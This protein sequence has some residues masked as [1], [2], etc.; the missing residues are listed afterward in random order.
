MTT[1]VLLFGLNPV[2]MYCVP[3]DWIYSS[4]LKPLGKLI[5][6]PPYPYTRQ[7][8]PLTDGV[9]SVGLKA[10]PRAMYVV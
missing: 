4:F 2:S 10:M 8:A 7:I 3:L 6:S 9:C 5:S 1:L